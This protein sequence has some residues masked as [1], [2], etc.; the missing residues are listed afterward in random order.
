MQNKFSMR[1]KS[2]THI[3][4]KCSSIDRLYE[5]VL[6][7]PDPSIV[8]DL[9]NGAL[10]LY[11]CNRSGICTYIFH[12]MEYELYPRDRDTIDKLNSIAKEYPNHL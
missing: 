6:T 4:R 5:V 2:F 3:I 10:G 7:M 8:V 9:Q 1:H 12:C 11:A